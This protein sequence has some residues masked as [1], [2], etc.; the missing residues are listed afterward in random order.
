M[1]PNTAFSRRKASSPIIVFELKLTAAQTRPTALGSRLKGLRLAAAHSLALARLRAEKYFCRCT[2]HRQKCFKLSLRLRAQ[3]LRGFFDSLKPAEGSRLR[4]FVSLM[5]L[6]VRSDL[7]ADVPS[8]PDD[9]AQVAHCAMRSPTRRT[10]LPVRRHRRRARKPRPLTTLSHSTLKCIVPP[11]ARL[12]HDA[13]RRLIS[14][15]E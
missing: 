3:T 8:A 2:C 7:H 11:L 13:S 6:Y 1:I 5:C 15:M 10:C 4:R 12:D 14:Q 9:G